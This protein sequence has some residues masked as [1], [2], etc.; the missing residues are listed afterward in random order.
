MKKNLQ[1]PSENFLWVALPFLLITLPLIFLGYG[2][3]SDIYSELEAAR[4]T[5][6][7]GIP[8][9]SRHPGYWLHE[10]LVFVVSRQGGSIAINTLT[11]AASL[12]ILYRCWNLA[13][14]LKISHKT[15]LILCLAFNPWF[16]IASTSAMDYTWTVLAVVVGIELLVLQ[17][18][19][20]GGVAGAFAIAFRLGSIFTLAGAALG[21]GIAMG[22]SKEWFKRAFLCGLITVLAGGLFYLPSWYVVHQNFSFLQGHLGAE[23]L[24]TLKMHLGRAV[25]KPIYLFGLLSFIGIGTL[26]MVHRKHIQFRFL[27]KSSPWAAPFLGAVLGTYALYAKYPI[28]I[29][30][31]LPGLPLFYLLLGAMLPRCPKWHLWLLFLSTL[32]YSFIS[33]SLASPN[34]PGEA[35]NASFGLRIVPGVLLEDIQKRLAFI[36]HLPTPEVYSY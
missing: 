16:L 22:F 20:R 27:L 32:S 29:S 13:T 30:Y 36:D 24:W 10:A 2:A 34:V 6:I 11:L 14:Q 7:E 21:Q 3:D 8:S 1:S 12:L 15:P 26:L 9:M 31:L 4:K 25:Y 33:L 19:M 28:E 23:E 18:P 5:W 35:S 17:K